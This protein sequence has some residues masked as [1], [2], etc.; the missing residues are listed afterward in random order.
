M[1]GKQIALI[2][3]PNQALFSQKAAAQYL[4]ISSKTLQELSDAG[5]IKCHEFVGRRTYK[6]EDL[7]TLRASLPEWQN[8]GRQI[9]LSA[10]S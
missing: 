4:G 6:F 1:V 2:Q 8:P 7:E 5:R 10:A 9:P 3:V